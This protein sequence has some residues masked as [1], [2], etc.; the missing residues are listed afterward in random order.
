MPDYI[1]D[2]HFHCATAQI[3][4]DALSG[5]WGFTE[6]DQGWVPATVLY[7]MTAGMMVLLLVLLKRRDPV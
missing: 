1:V 6:W 3:G 2:G 4:S 7:V 5:A